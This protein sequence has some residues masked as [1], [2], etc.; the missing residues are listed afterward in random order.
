VTENDLAFV[1]SCLESRHIR[2]TILELGGGYGGETCRELLTARGMKYYCTDMCEN[3]A[4]VDFIAHFETGEGIE[5][6]SSKVSF[7]TVLVLNVLEHT[8]EP[9]K[10]LDNAASLLVVGGKIVAATPCVWPIHNYPVDCCR[11]LPDWYRKYAK[12]S[13][14]KLVESHFV[15]IGYEAINAFRIGDL[16]QFPPDHRMLG[17]AGLRSRI[18]HKLFN[19]YGR[20]MLFRPHIAIGAVLEKP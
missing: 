4:R 9:I 18:V 14:L 1:E 2:G 11:L 19:T 7:E 15:F 6:I 10:V 5:T 17:V 20:G 12:R 8:F 16:D 13:G 3:G